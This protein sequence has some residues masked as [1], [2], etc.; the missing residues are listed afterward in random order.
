[1]SKIITAINAMVSRPDKIGTVVKSNI[2]QEE[3]YFV[4]DGKY[5]WSIVKQTNDYIL[6]FYPG[7]FDIYELSAIDGGDWESIDFITYKTSEIKTR[8]AYESF[9]NLYLIIQEK[10]YGLDKILD[11]II[12]D[13]AF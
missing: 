13:A 7:E 6:H 4:Y 12:G 9:S 1:M 11:D 8:E 5:Y 10:Q 2:N 3:Y